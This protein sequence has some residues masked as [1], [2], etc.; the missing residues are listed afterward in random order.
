MAHGSQQ[1]RGNGVLV[2]N[3]TARTTINYAPIGVTFIDITRY[4]NAMFCGNIQIA[5]I[6]TEHHCMFTL[7]E[8]LL[9]HSSGTAY[10]YQSSDSI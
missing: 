1:S 9:L 10:M 8:R 6:Y 3:K 5:D 7:T 4:S 2:S